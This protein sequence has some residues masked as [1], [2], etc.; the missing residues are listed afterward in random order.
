MCGCDLGPTNVEQGNREQ[1]L[2]L[3]NGTEPQDLDPHIVTGVTE[4]NIIS[5]LLEGL[6]GENPE[7]LEP[8]PGMAE[9]WAISADGLEYTFFIREDARWSNGD[10]VTAQDFVW[11]WQRML[12][13]ALAAEYAYQ[14]YPIR[15]ARAFNKGEVLDFSKVGVRAVDQTTLEVVLENPTPYFLSLLAHYS[16]FPV[17]P[18]TI[19]KYGPM[20]ARGSDWTR[21]GNFVGNGPFILNSWRLNYIIE[22]VKNPLYWDAEIVKLSAIRFYPI[23]NIQTEE[24]MFR[25]GAL[26]ATST[27]PSEKI[28]VYQAETPDLISISPYLGTYFYRFN[29]TRPPLDDARVRLA[30]SLAVDRQA[31]IDSVTKGGQIPAYSFTPPNTKGYFPPK[32]EIFYSL[33]RARALLAESGFPAGEGFPQLEL[34]S[35]TSDGH[36]RIAEAIQQLWKQGLGIDVQ[37]ANTDWKVYLSRTNQLDYDISR[38]GWIGDY[39]DPNTFLDMMLSDGGNNRTGWQ[40]QEYDKLIRRAAS[41]ASQAQRYEAFEQ[42]ETILDQ[43]A[44]LLPIYTYTRVALKDPSLQNWFSNIL[45]HHPYKYVYLQDD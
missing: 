17:H 26:H 27:T 14:L 39:P 37:L 29:V 9:Y 25:T 3:G 31:I 32:N 42:A 40:H 33:E 36:R 4:H 45:D 18:A 15:N 2:H 7:T 19:L 34:L 43:E 12:S 41:L 28:A 5:A 16:T 38:A 35:N 8:V 23:D 22:V 10:P 44:P 20:D 6:V 21:P 11:S 13:P 30:L 1:V 24:R